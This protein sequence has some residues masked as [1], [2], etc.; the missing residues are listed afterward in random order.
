MKDFLVFILL[1]FHFP[2]WTQPIND[3][4]PNAIELDY[5]ENWCSVESTYT[6][7]G[8]TLSSISGI[9]CFSDKGGDVWFKFVALNNN[10]TVRVI[11]DI[12][13]SD[14]IPNF[15]KGSMQYPK[16]ALYKAVSCSEI[17]LLT[18]NEDNGDHIAEIFY[19]ELS[20][21]MQYFIRVA[22]TGNTEGSF[23][24]C[25]NSFRI[26]RNSAINCITGG[27]LTNKASFSATKVEGG[28]EFNGIA[29]TCLNYSGEIDQK[30]YKWI[31]ASTGSLT[32]IIT[33]NNPGDDLDFV[34]YELSGSLNNCID[35]VALRCMASGANVDEP[36]SNWS[37]CTGATGLRLGDMDETEFPGCQP[38]ND[39]FAAEIEMVEGRAYA[40]VIINFSQ[41]DF[42]F[43]IEF[44][45]TGEF[46]QDI[47]CIYRESTLPEPDSFRIVP[48]G[49]SIVDNGV[50]EVY[51]PESPAYVEWHFIGAMG[52]QAV[53]FELINKVT[54]AFNLKD[55]THLL[56]ITDQYG[57]N[58]S[59]TYEVANTC[60]TD[61]E[62]YALPNILTPFDGNGQN[63][64]LVI[65]NLSECQSQD[66]IVLQTTI[67]N[68]WGDVVWT[69]KKA[70][71]FWDGRN[72]Q[73]EPLPEGTYYYHIRLDVKKIGIPV[74][75]TGYVTL[76]R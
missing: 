72:K 47:P 1:V 59:F 39:N 29:P 37:P 56:R 12:I 5:V 35:R 53:S 10:I 73:G 13:D 33:P 62:S 43:T 19:S 18:C 76:L 60:C 68:R 64:Q 20:P 34:L 54:R 71:E 58:S 41:S 75:K 70:D 50:I 46:L 6:N 49:C 51:L 8:S 21:G 22:S 23:Q 28:S 3:L 45:G 31:A 14:G 27:L 9:E 17:E 55:G 25:L 32:F 7:E 4:C 26:D 40:L 67:V 66:V 16:I 36:F 2:L 15:S 44:G 48:N 57:C 30:W 69:S 74:I 11:G 61:P 65:S 42:G 52:E 63:D 38:G 24:L